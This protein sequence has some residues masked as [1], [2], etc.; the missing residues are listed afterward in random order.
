MTFEVAVGATVL[1]VEV[2]DKDG[3]QLQ[4]YCQWV[5]AQI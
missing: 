2:E 1:V 5:V 4:K 3:Y